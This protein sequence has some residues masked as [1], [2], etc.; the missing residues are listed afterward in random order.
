MK[1]AT[2]VKNPMSVRNVGRPL[3][4]ALSL[5][6][7]RKSTLVRNPISASSVGRPSFVDLTLPSIRE[8]IRDRGVTE[9]HCHQRVHTVKNSSDG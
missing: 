1:E 9:K 6:D 4:V 8:F 3:A 7:T 2:V 5:V